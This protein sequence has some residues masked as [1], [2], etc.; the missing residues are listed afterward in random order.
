[1]EMEDGRTAEMAASG[2]ASTAGSEQKRRRRRFLR[3]RRDKWAK[4]LCVPDWMLYSNVPSDLNGA[5]RPEAGWFV[6]ARPEGT[7]C[8]VIATH[9]KTTS[10]SQNGARLHVWKSFL[11]GGS[12][13]TAG[14]HDKV[15]ILDAIFDEEQQRY[16]VVDLLSWRGMSMYDCPAEFRFYWL[17][18]NLAEAVSESSASAALE[19]AQMAA[20]LDS[21]R[22][23]ATADYSNF[24]IDPVPYWDCNPESVEEAY[25]VASLPYVRDGLLFYQKAA[26]YET[27]WTPLVLLWKDPFCTRYYTYGGATQSSVLEVA[28]AGRGRGVP[29]ANS[30]ED[31]LGKENQE[32]LE[33]E[34]LGDAMHEAL[35]G[36]GLGAEEA[37]GASA[38]AGASRPLRLLTLDGVEP[39][40]ENS[41][42]AMA[43]T[44]LRTL[45]AEPGDYVKIL[46][47]SCYEA[48]MTE[49]L[50][51]AGVQVK[52]LCSMSRALA[53]PS[54]KIQFQRDARNDQTL[55]FSALLDA[56]QRNADETMAFDG[57]GESDL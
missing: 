41:E 37:A 33:G 56:C 16:W 46:V 18:T 19:N 9:G 21:G 54:S 31:E 51:L 44:R 10:R 11:P 36:K 53:D 49:E 8:I 28:D 47:D 1:M 32:R 14:G 24:S 38:G 12:R 55:R 7:R 43:Q 48:D 3:L 34:N 30:E 23:G 57:F 29:A 45:G 50:V 25:Q 2:S 6:L 17:R 42:A 4:Q 40:M 26:F 39:V 13:A 15:T 52:Q 22:G 35:S 5:D 20:E 27:G